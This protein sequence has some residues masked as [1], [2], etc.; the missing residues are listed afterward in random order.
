MSV[1][2][3]RAGY[4]TTKP[5]PDYCPVSP[6]SGLD[7]ITYLPFSINPWVPGREQTLELH[8]LSQVPTFL[9]RFFD[10]TGRLLYVGITLAPLKRFRQHML[11]HTA[12]MMDVAQIVP[13]WFETREEAR[14]AE[15]EAIRTE[16]PIYN[17]EE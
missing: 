12:W 11:D 3:W 1:H 16:N 2:R 8:G 6:C 9:Y 7:D 13:T 17:I 10:S 5:Q 14:E 4:P 15:K